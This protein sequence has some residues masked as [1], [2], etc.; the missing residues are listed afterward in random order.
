MNIIDF[1]YVYNG[2]GT[3]I[4]DFNNDGLSDIFFTGNQ[5]S[6]RLYINKGDFKFDDITQKAG[7][8]GNGKWCS[9]VALVDINNDGWMD[10]Y[11]GATVSKVAAKRE[12]MLFVNQGAKPG[13]TPVFREMAK[14]Y[15]I[16]DDG[17]TTNAAF[18]DYDNDGD[19]DLY[20]LTNT[21]EENPNA[22]RDRI[23]DGSSPTT[24]R[25]YRNDPNPTLGHPVF[26]NVSKQEG[27]LSEGYGLGLNITDINRDGWKDVYVTNDYLS[28][29][30]LYINNHDGNN[31]H[32]G[33]TDQAPQ[34]FKHTSGAAMGNDVADIN[35][36]GLAD[37]VAV[38][39]LPRDNARKKMLMGANNYQT[40]LNNE[41]FKHTY[42]YTRNTLQLN[43]GLA[44]TPTGKHPVFSEIGLFSDVAETDW[45]WAPTLMDF[46]HDGY[47][48]LLITNGFPK[49]VTD[50]DFGSFRAESERIAEK[51]FMLA[52]I[53]V[54]KI[55]NYAFRNKGD[56][57]FEDVT[58]KWGL[59]LPSFSNGA[60]YGD[61]D[62]DGD[63]DYVVNN[64]NDSAFVYRNNLV[65]SKIDKA[66]YLRIKFAGEAQN[67]MGL[68][69]IVELHYG[70][71]QA[72]GTKQQVYEH[73]PYRGYLSTVEPIAHF[74]LGDVSTIDEVRIIWPGLN[75][76]PQ[77]Q[78]T[79][80]NV[81][82]N[83]VLAVDVRNAHEPVPLTPQPK[84][85]FTEV[86]D[87]LNI[88]YQH[89][90]PEHIDFNVQKLLP[91]K[92]S[93]FA[94]AV[95][96]GDVNGDG[97]DDLFIGGSRMNKGHFLIQTAAGS[98]VE[99]D[100]LP[101][102]AIS[103]AAGGNAKDKQEEDMGT[104]LFDAD[105]DGD[106]DLY[107]ASGGI[108]GNANTPTFQDR[109][110]LN[111]GKGVFTLDQ[112][113]LPACTVSKSCV[114]AIDFDRDGDLDLFVGGRVE[115]DHYPKPVS[116]FVF[117][118]DSKPG[119]AKFTDVTKAVAPA[120]Q[121]LGLVCDALWTD[122]DNDGWPDL[123]LAGEF[124]PLT[125]LRN[126]Q[127]KLQPVDNKLGNQKG[128]WNS[129]VAGDFDRDGDMDYI[130][131]NLGQ[132]ARMRASDKE[133]VRI[134]AGDF[135]NN[136]FYDAIPTIF[137]TDEKGINREFTFHG[138]D[139]LIKQMIAMRKRFPLYKDFTQASID[140]LLTPEERE[141]ALVLE[142]NYL[143]SAYIE[144]K[145]NGA[146]AIHPLP[147]PAQMGPI[148]GM[149]ADDVDHDGNLDV[150]LVGN[151]YSGEVMMGRYD[152]LNGMWLRGNGKGEFAPQS[153]A[154]S[155]FYVPGNAK[156]LAQLTTANGH[157]LLVAT[158]NRG[159]L[160]VFRNS[161][162][163]PSVRLRPTDASALLTFADGK[164]QKVEFSYGN[165]FLSQSAR[166][167]SIDP[168][169]KSVEITDS[170][171]RK[172]Q[173]LD[174]V[175]LVVR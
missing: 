134:Y 81:K 159:R 7:V 151:D 155:G 64:I 88:T 6:N 174:Q 52:Q 62:N 129:L 140:K 17:H 1:E 47:R 138:R 54:I 65:E 175:K 164:K 108:E 32:T 58:E 71:G 154:T 78:Q 139:D 146:F 109:L 156:G 69:A 133:P 91:H 37:I 110:Y 97:L 74:G 79:L 59:K 75:G 9:G 116:S 100:L 38:D 127:G 8:T 171:G 104:L 16:A 11:V 2:G 163:V 60:A 55:S 39:M 107:I 72:G 125:I 94:P 136:G 166:T 115:P 13:E 19:L 161:K 168:Q 117:R 22:Y 12:N 128:W 29:D 160:C 143:Q 152:A 121:D 92:L 112:Q 99:N 142:A 130:A 87:S 98:F 76:S 147:T 144:N 43:Q 169:V 137:I 70:N 30:L 63:V 93:Q 20:V 119:Q 84:S 149:V 120:L 124:M 111:N 44:P 10:I 106:L 51:S 14:E 113:A 40:Y 122:Y 80:R 135:D 103:V 114:K 89:V 96:A 173:E 165:S 170:R 145:G 61:L 158:Q 33:F 68:G 24:D 77:K 105:G 90:E 41:Q 27:I 49:D 131:G 101:G 86:T 26:T 56:L 95:S 5:V 28:D 157:E 150:M 53:P 15:G 148:F 66:N 23:L 83:Q 118:N 35:N 21:I 167:L 25:L 172:R 50:R 73:S 42:Q 48:D 82:T 141:K 46:D 67:R 3:A 126:Q 45:S 31:R 57:T 162:S 85:L 132:N 18:F 4:G 34:Y 123:M 36:D 153:I 102:A